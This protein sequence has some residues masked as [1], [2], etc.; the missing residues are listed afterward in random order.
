MTHVR[1]V[2]RVAN[3]ENVSERRPQDEA[4]LALTKPGAYGL[5]DVVLFSEV[6]W[7][8]LRAL[9]GP[10]WHVVQMGARGSAEAGVAIA[11]RLPMRRAGLTIGSRPV[12]GVRMRPILTARTIRRMSAVHAPPPRT[13]FARALYLARVRLTRGLVGGDFNVAPAQM[14]RRFG[15]KY[16]G[17]G[18]LGAL[19]PRW[20]KVSR[21][22]PVDI[23]SDH[24]AVDVVVV[25]PTRRRRTP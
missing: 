14:R 15:R 7:L 23:D 18:V 8:N 20:W 21:P 6:S 9:A 24:P 13:P 22:R 5:P 2:V 25:V 10:E 12:P 16:R 3:A 4:H 11:S 17:I 1:L 19:V